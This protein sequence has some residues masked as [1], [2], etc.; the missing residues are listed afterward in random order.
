LA[1][2]TVLPGCGSQSGSAAGTSA[3]PEPLPARCAPGVFGPRACI[4][5]SPQQILSRAPDVGVACAVPNS[6]ACDRVGIGVW[7]TKPASGVSAEID[8]RPLRLHPGGFGGRGPTYWEGYLHPAG[9]LS[10]ALRVVPDRGRY[11]WQGRHPKD[12]QLRIVVRRPDGSTRAT[13]LTVT[14]GPGWG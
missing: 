4:P 2:L 12:A 14:L 9:L 11:G 5:A 7:L 6:I 3:A 8:G 13:Q 10:G 1:I